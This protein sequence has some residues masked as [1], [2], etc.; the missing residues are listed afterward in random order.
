MSWKMRLT[1]NGLMLDEVKSLLQKSLRRKEACLA[2]KAAKELDSQLRWKTILTCFFEDHALNNVDIMKELLDL[3]KDAHAAVKLLLTKCTVCRIPACMATAYTFQEPKWDCQ[4]TDKTFQDLIE[5]GAADFGKLLQHVRGAWISGDI[6]QLARCMK[7]VV[8]I[9][10]HDNTRRLTEKGRAFMIHPLTTLRQSRDIAIPLLTLSMLSRCKPYTSAI[11]YYFKL[12]LTEIGVS[13]SLVLFNVVAWRKFKD[14]IGTVQFH[15]VDLPPTVGE[16]DDMP[17]WAVDKHTFRG[18]TGC[19]TSKVVIENKRQLDHQRLKIF[20]GKRPRKGLEDFFSEGSRLCVDATFPKDES[21]WEDAKRLY[22]GRPLQKQKTYMMGKEYWE[23][24]KVQHHPL[25]V[26]KRKHTCVEN[27]PLLRIPCGGTH[28]QLVRVD[29]ENAEV[30]KGPYK[31]PNKVRQ[32]AQ[33]HH[34]MINVLKD[35]HTLEPTVDGNYIRFDLM[36]DKKKRFPPEIV[37]IESRY[38]SAPVDFV[39]RKSLGIIHVNELDVETI[40]AKIPWTFWAHFM[41]R[42]L[43]NVGDSGLYNAITDEDMSFLYGID[44]D[45]TRREGICHSLTE[46]MFARKPKSELCHAIEKVIMNKH[47]KDLLSCLIEKQKCTLCKE[48]L[49]LSSRLKHLIQLLQK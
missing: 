26:N 18:R 17:S 45:E 19:D 10:E 42:Y 47:K 20:H 37:E 22:R 24:L 7:L 40:E 23:M 3:K 21:Y 36:Y 35:R 32:V 41:F 38:S 13:A 44:F 6:N 27:L 2:L 39:T 33:I 30:V 5:P 28:K 1:K 29:L 31:N 12:F 49:F 11:S 43:L 34:F 25:F 16:L 46:C 9:H 15:L 14:V 8:L 4:T 48:V